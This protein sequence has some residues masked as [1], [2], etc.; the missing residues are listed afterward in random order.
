MTDIDK[1]VENNAAAEQP[2]AEPRMERPF[3]RKV[4][5][6]KKQCAFCVDRITKIDYKE[7]L[8]LRKYISERAKILPRRA[9]GM[10]AYHQRVLA[11]AIKKAR[12]LAIIPYTNNLK[13]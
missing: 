2:Q 1:A 7:G 4:L 12:L 10:C 9:T 11:K 6:K 8:R 13:H 5:R 3:L